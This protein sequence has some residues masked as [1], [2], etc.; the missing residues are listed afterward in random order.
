MDEVFQFKQMVVWDKG[1][2]GM[3]WHYRRSYEVVLVAQKPGAKC[4]W[5][6]TTRKVENII[7][8]LH[9]IIPSA[10]Q[11]P[12]EKPSDLAGFFILLHSLPG[13]IVLDPFAGH[14]STGEAAVVLGRKFQGIELEPS[15]AAEARDRVAA[16]AAQAR[17]F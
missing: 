5:H 9:K 15:F 4:K 12:T 8:G 6:D 7:R 2:M 17:L 10:R 1:P 14:G 16:A 3:G 11:H 13:E